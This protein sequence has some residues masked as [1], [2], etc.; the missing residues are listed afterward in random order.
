MTSFYRDD[1][2]VTMS[3]AAMPG[4]SQSETIE[5]QRIERFDLSLDAV[6]GLAQ[7]LH[8]RAAYGLTADRADHEQRVR[9]SLDYRI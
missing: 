5:Q 7:D 2:E 8:L 3:E 6:V 1:F 9:V 4:L